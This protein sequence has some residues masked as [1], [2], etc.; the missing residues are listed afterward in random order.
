MIMSDIPSHYTGPGLVDLQMNGYCGFDFN[1]DPD[2][3][4]TEHFQCVADALRRR[5][6]VAALPTIITDEPELMKLRASKFNAILKTAPELGEIFPGLHIEGPFISPDDGPRG[7]HPKKYCKAPNELPCYLWELQ[8]ASGNRIK[9]FTLAPEVE[10]AMDIIGEADGMDICVGIGHTSATEGHLDTAIRNGAKISTHLG[11][12]SHQTLARHRNYIQYQLSKDELFASFIADGHHIPFYALK[13]YIRAKSPD[14]SVL[15][16]DA[17]SAA[18][19]GPGVYRLG[20]DEV[21]VRDDLHVS[22]PGEP[23]LAGSALTL[24]CAVLNIVSY[25]DV[26]FDLAWKMASETPASLIGLTELPEVSVNISRDGF[27]LIKQG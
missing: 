1:S 13:N 25:C 27:D 26:S 8:E 5:G 24:D 3:W 20:N 23:N 2:S 19:V 9:I 12:G 15:V 16:T 6:V 10:G 11:N 22:K 7:A 14:R 4:K 17:I 21:V 18:D